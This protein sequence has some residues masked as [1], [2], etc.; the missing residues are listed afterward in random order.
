[1]EDVAEAATIDFA[2]KQIKPGPPRRLSERDVVMGFDHF[3]QSYTERL[4]K[5]YVIYHPCKDI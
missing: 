2:F 1:M 4:K 5:Q 3:S